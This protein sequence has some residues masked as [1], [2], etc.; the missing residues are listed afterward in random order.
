MSTRNAEL[1]LAGVIVARS[2]SLLFAK[3]AL[4]TMSVFNLLGVRFCV[5]FL[6]L[7][8]LFFRQLRRAGRRDILSGML[9]GV[10]FFAVMTTETYAL[11]RTD[12]STVSFL[13]NTA[14]VIVP[15]AQAALERRCPGRWELMAAGMT[16]TGVACLTLRG[17]GLSLGLGEGLCMVE[18]VLYAGAIM[19]TSSLSKKGDALVMGVVQ[20]GTMGVLSAAASLLLEQPHLPQTGVEWGCILVLAL[21]CSCFGFTFQPVAQRY[22][23][24]ERAG[25]FCALNPL[26]ATILGMIFLHER[27]GVWGVV[28][29]ALILASILVQ[30]VGETAPV[31]AGETA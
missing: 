4:E 24:A 13:V 20:I 9:L 5:A 30:S 12:S 25:Q 16:L 23:S 18:A 1:L 3:T 6:V 29:A 10:A 22:V 2:T 26:S 15:L 17:G 8:V 19:L 14:I 21:V 28:G 31:T 27:L 7:A 11:K